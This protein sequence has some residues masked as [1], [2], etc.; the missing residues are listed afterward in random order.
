MLNSAIKS[1]GP[2]WYTT[3][4]LPLSS[5][6]VIISELERH[7]LI[8]ESSKMPLIVGVFHTCSKQCCPHELP[9]NEKDDDFEQRKRKTHDAIR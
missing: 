8:F 1:S 9:E 6:S 4:G 3:L 7:R 5:Y 2:V